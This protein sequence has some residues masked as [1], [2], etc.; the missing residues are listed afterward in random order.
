[1]KKILLI[2][3]IFLVCFST[4]V[5]ATTSSD[6]QYWKPCDTYEV[7]EATASGGLN[8]IGCYKDFESAKAAMIRSGN[9][10]AVVVT[11]YKDKLKIVAANYALV[12]MSYSSTQTAYVY[13]KSSLTGRQYTY[14]HTLDTCMGIDAALS[15]TAQTSSTYSAKVTFAGMT[16]WMDINDVEITPLIWTKAASSYTVSSTEIRHN[17]VNRPAF[18]Y[19][20]TA[21]RTIGPKPVML[22]PGKYYSYDGHYFY[23]SLKTMLNDYKNNNHN[24]SVN[25]DHPYYNYYMYLPN[26][27]RT[28][29]SSINIDE[30]IRNTLGYTK[31]AY[32]FTALPGASR[33]Y[34]SGTYFYNSQEVYGANA[35]LT[36][37]L[38]INET[39]YGRSSLAVTKNNGFGLNAVDS[40][41]YQAANWYPTY[42]ASILG[43]ADGYITNFY[44]K[45]TSKVY[46]GSQYGNKGIGM[47]VKYASD[48]YWSEKMAANYYSF[49]KTHGLQDYNYYQEAI[50]TGVVGAYSEPRTSSKKIYNYQEYEDAI[51]IVSETTG[52]TV[53]GS[54]IWYEVMTDVNI[55]NNYNEIDA[56]YNWNKH[57]Y[58]PASYVIKINTPVNGYQDPN[59]VTKY[60]DSNYTYDLLIENKNLSPKVGI[61][62]K[63]TNYYYDSSLLD[64]TSKKLVKDRYVM[65]YAIA[66][67][68]NHRAVAYQVTS[69]YFYDQK[70]W[71][72]SDSIR[73][74]EMAYGK[75]KVKVSSN[76]YARVDSTTSE[77]NMISGHYDGA[78]FPIIEEKVVNGNTWYK[79]PVDLDGTKPEYGWSISYDAEVEIT[80][81]GKTTV[82][83]TPPVLTGNDIEINQGDE[84]DLSSL[85]TAYDE[86]D[87]DITSRIMIEGTVDTNTPGVYNITYKVKDSS[88]VEVTK[89]IKVTVKEVVVEPT[90][91]PTPEPSQEP[92]PEPTTDPGSDITDPTEIEYKEADSSFYLK[93]LTYSNNKYNI[94]GYLIIKD[95]D[96]SNLVKYEL[97]LKD[98]NSDEEYTKEISRWTENTPFSLGEEN[99]YNN[100][101]F[102]GEFSLEDIPLGDYDLYMRAYKGEYYTEAILSNTFNLDIPK[103]INDSNKGYNLSTRMN[104]KNRKIEL[105]VRNKLITT[106]NAPTY[107]TMIN[108][109]DSITFSDNNMV[110]KGT[111][112]NYGGTYDKPN[113]ITRTL[114]LENT[115]TYETFAFD[116]SSTNNGSYVVTSPDNKSKDYAW[117]NKEI[118]VSKL[119]AGTYSMNI[120][121]KTQDAEDYGELNYLFGVIKS[122]SARINNKT[123]TTSIN[124]NR[125]NRIELIVE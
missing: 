118:D 4:K 102:N 68:E 66:Y 36:M 65:V 40:N 20:G 84:I 114:I 111:S 87:K 103:R 15:D 18:D 5:F 33:L 12:D 54:N 115:T 99:N 96:N 80:K 62:L 14:V 32:G 69:D 86:E 46:F 31:D 29:Y 38:S 57:L 108:N 85:V 9:E 25:K 49:D 63:D 70:A 50:V 23:N 123:Y 58:V 78:Y 94:S 39:G 37:S 81:F 17:Y 11:I 24:N 104:L 109:Y 107:R 124:K 48:I 83:N 42:A 105:N 26:H 88:N 97:V 52:E 110:I 95:H 82:I 72:P 30:Y 98:M 34:G 10:N 125:N 6:Y 120:Y 19:D 76:T 59:N 73:F 21:G 64:N 116:L 121:T 117:F 44:S 55:D 47:G 101:W 2:I 61:S 3:T 91:D 60:K 1:M 35:L 53:N 93:G 119:P 56:A 89:I 106:S 122:Q 112:Y 7:S 75:Q 43:F 90:P 51:I 8:E 74:V 28:N 13:E 92:T 71:V 27:T 79:M 41:P 100:S 22:N 16:G 113:Y 45:A 77:T 67:D